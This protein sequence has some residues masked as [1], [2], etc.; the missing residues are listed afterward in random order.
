MIASSTAMSPWSWSVFSAL[1]ANAPDLDFLPGLLVGDI[2]RFHQS[3][4]HS[5]GAALIF[6][7]AAALVAFLFGRSPARI[8]VAGAA[9]YASHLLLDLFCEDKRAPFGIPL[10]WPLSSE[11][12]AMPW[13]IFKG[14]KHGIAGEELSAFVRHLFSWENGTVVGL[15]MLTLLPLLWLSWYVA[16]RASAGQRRKIEAARPVSPTTVSHA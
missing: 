2:N 7:L 13:S 6:G 10:I 16:R 15:E 4:S 12:V 14:V 5:L 3:L 11:H 8:G 9:L 1:A